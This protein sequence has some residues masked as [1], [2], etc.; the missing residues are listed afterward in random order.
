MQLDLTAI[1]KACA[2]AT[3]GPWRV[4]RGFSA[5]GRAFV[6]GV[7]HVPP[8]L[9]HEDEEDMASPFYRYDA[10]ICETDS[11]HYGP[12]EKDANFIANAREWVPVLVARVRELEARPPANV[13]EET[14][15]KMGARILELEG[16]EGLLTKAA[17]GAIEKP[18]SWEF[19]SEAWRE[20]YMAN[21]QMLADFLAAAIRARKT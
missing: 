13:D 12:S 7:Y 11:G 2:E 15:R 19:R 8:R 1:E 6:H 10:R 9:P 4:Q 5:S 18:S 21:G 17:R 14:W 20:G 3:P 16:L